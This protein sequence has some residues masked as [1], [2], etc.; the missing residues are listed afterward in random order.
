[1]YGERK[2]GINDEI[3]DAALIRAGRL[4]TNDGLR[5]GAFALIA[6]DAIHPGL[7][8]A[9]L[10]FLTADHDAGATAANL[11]FRCLAFGVEYHH[12]APRWI[13]DSTAFTFCNGTFLI[14]TFMSLGFTV[15]SFIFSII[16][17]G[18]A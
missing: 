9:A 16:S 11:G 13:F 15:T 10:G 3:T 6:D 12:P 5:F 7:E 17:L 14:V 8:L 18:A 1:M 2:S 4:F